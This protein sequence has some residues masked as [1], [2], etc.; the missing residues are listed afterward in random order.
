MELLDDA[1]RELD[2]ARRFAPKDGYTSYHAAAVHA[3]LGEPEPAL[4]ALKEAQ[5]RGYYLRSEILRNSDLDQL[6]GHPEFQKLV[7]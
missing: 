2:E 3:L 1:R 4:R 6:R 7:G 5:D